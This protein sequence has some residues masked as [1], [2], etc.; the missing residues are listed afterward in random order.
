[1]EYLIRHNK[2]N[3]PN[4]KAH[5]LAGADTLCRMWGAGGMNK[6]RNWKVSS[7][8]KGQNVCTMCVNN[9]GDK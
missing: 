1:M 4:G 9:S 8:T 6:R 7:T 2:Q 5:I 3:K